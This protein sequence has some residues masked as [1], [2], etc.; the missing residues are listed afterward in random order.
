MGAGES[1]S[2]EALSS[3]K[4][5]DQI[6]PG[7]VQYVRKDSVVFLPN[8]NQNGVYKPYILTA[9]PVPNEVEDWIAVGRTE[10]GGYVLDLHFFDVAGEGKFVD[11]SDLDSSLGYVEPVAYAMSNNDVRIDADVRMYGDKEAQP[12]LKTVMHIVENHNNMLLEQERREQE[13]EEWNRQ[14]ERMGRAALAI[15]SF[16][17][18]PQPLGM[19]VNFAANTVVYLATSALTSK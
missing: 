17:P 2:F 5:I 6:Y 19:G 18:M 1:F 14:V 13:R 10:D 7:E 3:E 12:D 9:M 15:V 8:S 16:L 11:R 4:S